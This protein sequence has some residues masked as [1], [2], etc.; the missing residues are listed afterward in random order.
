MVSLHKPYL[1]VFFILSTGF[2]EKLAKMTSFNSL[3]FK[4]ISSC[5]FQ[6]KQSSNS[7]NAHIEN[8]ITFPKTTEPYLLLQFF[9]VAGSKA[10]RQTTFNRQYLKFLLF[11]GKRKKYESSQ[12]IQ[13][14]SFSSKLLMFSNEFFI[15]ELIF[16]IFC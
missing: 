9:F 15:F 8:L 11:S 6:N 4:K 10:A 2:L 14:I 12:L 5:Y 7:S 3:V 13:R 1:A 16:F